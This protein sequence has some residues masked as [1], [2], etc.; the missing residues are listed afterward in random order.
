MRREGGTERRGRGG[1]IG[2]GGRMARK[3]GSGGLRKRGEGEE[4]GGAKRKGEAR[5]MGREEGGEVGERYEV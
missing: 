3:H 4:G 2:E 5:W 1:V